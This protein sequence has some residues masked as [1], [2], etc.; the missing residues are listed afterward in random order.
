[1]AKYKKERAC[2]RYGHPKE[3]SA[4][5]HYAGKAHR[6]VPHFGSEGGKQATL[7]VLSLKVSMKGLQCPIPR[8]PIRVHFQ[9]QV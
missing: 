1:M 3:G 8:G 5:A 7:W 2:S 9:I 6:S 4:N